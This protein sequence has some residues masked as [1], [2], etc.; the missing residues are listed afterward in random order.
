LLELPTATEVTL[1]V[2][3]T[4]GQEVRTL[5]DHSRMP[6]GRQRIGWDGTDDQGRSLA[7]GL[8]LVRLKAGG[9]VVVRKLTLL[10]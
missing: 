9:Q 10:R 8:Y 6:A 5:V 1:R 4:L 7:S 3:N 2:Y